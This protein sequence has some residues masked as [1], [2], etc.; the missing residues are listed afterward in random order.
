MKKATIF[1]CIAMIS[2]SFATSLNDCDTLVF[3]KEG[4]KT[5]MTSYNADGKAIG[6]TKTIYK[7]VDKNGG[8]MSV[9]ATQENYDKKGKLSVSSDFTIKCLNGTL[10]FDMKLMLPQQQAESFKDFE[11]MV[12]GAD[13]EIPGDLTTGSTL[14]DADI[15]FSFK[16]KDG[17]P[18]PMMNMSV[19]ISNRKVEGKES[20]TTTAGTFECYKITEDV[21]MK[22]IFK[23]HAKVASWFSKEVGT[24]KTE[25]YKENGKLTGKT[26]LTEITK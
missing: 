9:N 2:M 23:I 1:F 6:T 3:F 12:E 10:L 22:T 15:K 13:K 24:V 4:V 25:S 17:T 8:T 21:E 14:K 18:M 7:K 5:T 11:M 26:E 19:K 16:T 20:I